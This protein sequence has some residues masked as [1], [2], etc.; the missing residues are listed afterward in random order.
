MQIISHRGY[1][2][3]NAEKNSETAFRRALKLGFGI[4]T[5]IRDYK[6]NLVISHDLPGETALSLENFLG[7][8]QLYGN[9]E[10][11]ALNIKADG[12]QELLK[13][14]LSEFKI[15]N[16]FVFDMAIPDMLLYLR[17]RMLVFTRLSEYE[18]SPVFYENI[19]GVWI[20]C[21]EKDWIS[22]LEIIQHLEA[23]KKVCLVSPEIHQRDYQNLWLKLLKWEMYDYE[24]LMLC[25]DFPELGR[26]FFYG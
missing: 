6:G 20:D 1:W 2:K 18:L 11:L 3:N 4:E 8:Y 24:N 26:N 5:D 15:K 17:E 19:T 7:L 9:D 23:G 12:L 14:K 10:I 21:F 22:K 16:Y 25:T 13:K